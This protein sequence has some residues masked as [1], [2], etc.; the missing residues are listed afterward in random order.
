M[1]KYPCAVA[2]ASPKACKRDAAG[3][4]HLW[5]KI[6]RFLILTLHPGM[7]RGFQRL[8]VTLWVVMV[9]VS[10][11]LVRPANENEA[12]ILL[13]WGSLAYWI[14][15]WLVSWTVAGFRRP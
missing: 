10:L 4:Q 2:T 14:L 11:F 13:F 8:A 7:N 3:V 9:P 6:A 1:S 15:F 12:F 5:G